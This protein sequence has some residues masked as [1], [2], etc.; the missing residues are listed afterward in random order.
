M[1]HTGSFVNAGHPLGMV[2]LFL[3][4]VVARLAGP[5]LA[6]HTTATGRVSGFAARRAIDAV[7][8]VGWFFDRL[9]V[10]KHAA[11]RERAEFDHRVR[12]ASRTTA[13]TWM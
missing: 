8:V 2:G 13:T 5:A 11:R 10:P 12:A 4:L 7:A 3:V 1:R 6:T 9:P